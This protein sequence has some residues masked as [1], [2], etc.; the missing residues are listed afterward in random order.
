MRALINKI[1]SFLG[2]V[3]Q[4]LAKCSTPNWPELRGSTVVIIVSMS[5]L[6]VFSFFVD[7]GFHYLI[8]WMIR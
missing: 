6:G 8:N 4:E 2:E 5:I 7:L 1:K 3:R